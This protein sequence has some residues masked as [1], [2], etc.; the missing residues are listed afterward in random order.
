[1][2][3]DTLS[4][5]MILLFV[6]VILASLLAGLIGFWKGIYKTTL[7]TIV[8]TILIVVLVFVSPYIANAIGNINIQGI[9]HSESA[10]T[11]QTYLANL[12]TEAGLISPISG[13]SIYATVF[14]IVNS[15]LAFL[16]FFLGMVVIQLIASLLTL[17]LYQGIF[18]FILP[19]E[20]KKERK[21][22]KSKKGSDVLQQGLLED[23]G[24]VRKKAKKTWPLLKVPGAILG[25]VQQF[26][27]VIVLLAPFSALATNALK[28]RDG[29]DDILGTVGVNQQERDRISGYMD[30]V[31]SSLL[32]H[33]TS[34][35]GFDSLV[36]NKATAVSVNG[37]QVSFN[38]LIDSVF[39]VSKPLFKDETISYDQASKAVTV[40]FAQL[41]SKATVTSLIDSVINN[42]MMMALVPPLIDVGM[43]Y[44]SGN[45]FAIEQLDFSNVD[46]KNELT[47]I[48][49]IYS[50]V[51]DGC[52]EPM[53][54]G[55]KIDF[56]N[57]TFNTSTL[58]DGQIDG[59]ADAVS[60]LGQLQTFK[61]NIS[62][63]VSALAHYLHNMGYDVLPM[64]SEKYENVDWS[65]DLRIYARAA[66]R[67]FRNIGFD[68]TSD[69]K[70][71][72]ITQGMLTSMKDADKRKELC[73][74]I[75][76][77][78]DKDKQEKG[79]L[80]T[81]LFKVISVPTILSSTLSTVPSLSSFVKDIDFDKIFQGYSVAKYRNEFNT[82]FDM[83]DI[84][85]EKNS[86]ID[87]EHLDRIDIRDPNTTDQLVR[88][89]DKSVDSNLFKEMYPS[90]MKSLL[91]SND[92]DFSNYLY[93]LTPYNFNYDSDS[94]IQDFKTLLGLMPEIQKFT[95]LMSDSTKGTA[96]KITEMVN[97]GVIDDLLGFVTGSSFFNSDQLTGVTSEKQK[98]VNVYTFLNGLFN[99]DMFKEI[100][101]RLPTLE[102][103]QFDADDW[104][105]EIKT[106]G[107]VLKSLSKNADFIASESKKITDIKDCDAVGEMISTAM[108]SKIFGPSIL[109]IIDSSLNDYF[110]QIGLPLKLNEMR[111][112][113]W[114]ED[115]DDIAKLLSLIQM[116]D[117]E[118][119]DFGSLDPE[120]LNSMLTIF[121]Q[122]NI[123]NP[124]KQHVDGK[125]PFGEAIYSIF[126][127]NH[128][129]SLL[130]GTEFSK[131][132]FNLSSMTGWTTFDPTSNKTTKS[133]KNYQGDDVDYPYSEKGEIHTLCALIS[134]LQKYMK[135]DPDAFAD[136]KLP[137]T[138]ADDIQDLLD[139]QLLRKMLAQV[140]KNVISS[141]DMPKE[142]DGF[143]S[144]IDFDSFLNLSSEEAKN[145]ISMLTRLSKMAVETYE[146]TNRLE[147]IFS[148]I[149]ELQEK[150]V[151]PEDPSS[152]TLLDE[153][154]ELLDSL[155]SSKLLNTKKAGYKFSPMGYFMKGIIEMSGLSSSVTMIDHEGYVEPVLDGMLLDIGSQQMASE[156]IHLKKIL[157]LLQGIGSG[158]SG[159]IDFQISGLEKEKISQ[160][161]EAM[162]DSKVFYR[163]PVYMLKT[164]VNQMNLAEYIKDPKDDTRTIHPFVFDIHIL[165]P[166]DVKRYWKNDI[167]HLLNI[168]FDSSLKDMIQSGSD[169]DSLD[170]TDMDLG[171]LYEMGQMNCFKENR[172]YIVYHLLSKA[173]PKDADGQVFTFDT[174]LR[175][176]KNTPYG[177]NADV[178]IFED[179]LFSIPSK[180]VFL[181]DLDMVKGLFSSIYTM[182][183][184][185]DKES[186]D[187]SLIHFADW[188]SQ[189]IDFTNGE[190]GNTDFYRSKLASEILAGALSQ[191][192]KNP[193]L[194]RLHVDGDFFYQND[195]FF[196]NPI[197]G[198]GL[199]GIIKMTTTKLSADKL[200]F[201]KSELLMIFTLLGRKDSFA[202]EGITSEEKKFNYFLSLSEYENHN[203][204]LVGHTK[205][206]TSSENVKP[207][208]EYITSLPVLENGTLIPT[209]IAKVY[210]EKGVVEP[211][212]YQ[213]KIEA[214]QDY[215]Q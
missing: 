147:Y 84:L 191:A 53:L 192:L 178:W 194:S 52:I 128:L 5:L 65:D 74:L 115:S 79:I 99:I 91:F 81:T 68:I 173:I 54:T 21:A 96:T 60:E 161:L 184:N 43:N 209:T 93:G 149:F 177:E 151:R 34:L 49:S 129:S 30:V 28:N 196:I 8:K 138:F 39:D 20:N 212:F 189:C 77:S 57:F 118:H 172:S 213:E 131:D 66:L 58:T 11:L 75:V 163:Y 207:L 23:D 103:F 63:I 70:T 169:F 83:M 59:Y 144:S 204:K 188:M 106:I 9:V 67:F 69:F 157:S 51:Y 158:A 50:E 116:M 211:V 82:M 107:S 206:D 146:G 187:F 117:L 210:E 87:L 181:H 183:P 40:N 205:V 26:L 120:R 86:A 171:F 154:D 18:R 62:H 105:G 141:I 130:G 180:T 78:D 174:I 214:I 165:S 155:S 137:D 124:G 166:D 162:M 170:V 109:Q 111:N 32:Y 127:K 202:E 160:L 150:H 176:S 55:E 186:T 16:V 61:K 190:D 72:K 41:L 73:D 112:A 76:G 24:T 88:L 33:T 13:L 198:N 92:F 38:G 6:A 64:E 208:E 113:Y 133:M 136:G 94:F 126:D 140:F 17:I 27:F 95:S 2:S 203:S 167:D 143:I 156:I 132:L 134:H 47:I 90:L 29:I 139:S 182:V 12:I 135:N 85:F 185:L 193:L 168:I 97:L 100:G 101:F 31:D 123:I 121:S 35:F 179:L 108:D 7:K 15:L 199:D 114:K 3:N 175:E 122:M 71:D 46:W 153:L 142:L 125:D 119:L 22:R 37:T 195:Y 89:L 10:I 215:I 148:H 164:M 145:E 19:V 56:K 159:K 200:Y 36:M 45:T 80:D 44:I 110:V 42:P 102:E 1:M 104:D 98:N 25:A 14:A 152:K 4:L 48:S 197:E 201:S